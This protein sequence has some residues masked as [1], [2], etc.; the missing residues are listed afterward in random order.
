[1]AIQRVRLPRPLAAVA[2]SAC[3]ACSS[4]A[5]LEA[6]PDLRVLAH[7]ALSRLDR[8]TPEAPPC[9]TG[10]AETP[11][12]YVVAVAGWAEQAGLRPG[13]Q[14]AGVG[15]T[16]ATALEDRVRAYRRARASE[17]FVLDVLRKGRPLTLSL[18]C[19][20]QPALFQAERRTLEAA[21]RGD[22]DGCIAAAREARQLA[23]FTAYLTLV[24]EHA[25][26]KAKGATPD[27]PAGRE[28]AALQAEVGRTLVRESRYVPGGIQNV[29]GIVSQMIEDLKRF[30]FPDHAADVETQLAAGLVALP[31]LELT[32]MDNSTDEDGFLVERR[33][34]MSGPFQ[35]LVTLPPNTRT[36]VDTSV[37]DDVTFC[38]RV[39]AFKASA[40]S[41]PSNEACAVPA[42]RGPSDG[43]NPGP[44]KP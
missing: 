38:Y 25:C 21:S 42:P 36:Y 11:A 32:W 14:I 26:M 6:P 8:S 17:P 10:W 19:R 33:L 9:G 3:V 16:P 39:K 5:T 41:E 27:T 29:R 24:R 23:D 15:G 35:L 7:D 31:R 18:P 13:D 22:W 12:G 40:H 37:Q 43:G 44:A 28:F 30:G 20:H 1:M 4:P 2:F 34:G